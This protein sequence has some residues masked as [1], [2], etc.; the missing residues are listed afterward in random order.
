MKTALVVNESLTLR[1]IP[2][3]AFEYRLGSRSALDWVI[4]QYRVRR[5]GAGQIVSDP[6]R[7]DDPEYIVNLIGRVIAI[8]LRTLDLIAAL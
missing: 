8:S 5:D 4:E 3:R 1:G 6:N 2:A 7:P